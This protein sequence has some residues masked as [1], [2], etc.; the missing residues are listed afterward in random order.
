MSAET[1]SV[2]VTEIEQETDAEALPAVLREEVCGVLP[3]LRETVK[4]C[5]VHFATLKDLDDFAKKIGYPLT[6]E[7]R[8][9][10]WPLP[11]ELDAAPTIARAQLPLLYRNAKAALAECDRLDECQSWADKAMALASYAK[12]AKDDALVS[13]AR[14]IRARAVRRCGELLQ[15]IEPQGGKRTDLEPAGGVPTRSEAARQAGLPIKW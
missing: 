7:T 9:L 11:A 15:T 6:T 4:S 12:Q 3:E 8:R 14:R 2:V 13:Y 5:Y 10:T 1:H